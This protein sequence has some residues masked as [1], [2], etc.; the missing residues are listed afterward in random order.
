M[1]GQRRVPGR[2]QLDELRALGVMDLDGAAKAPREARR[3]DA[4]ALELA[5]LRPARQARGDEQRLP[6]GRDAGPLELGRGGCQRRLPRIVERARERERRR[7]DDDR[8]APATGHERL[9]RLAREREAKRVAHGRMHVGDR[10][11][12]RRR[13]QH[14]RVVG[15]V[16]HGQAGAGEDRDAL[17]Y[18]IE[19]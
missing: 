3:D 17:H 8:R 19:R 2:L 14:D 13:S 5:L 6:L 4:E 18:G 15:Y 7:L 11:A 12:R 10:L 9:E 1:D 16:D